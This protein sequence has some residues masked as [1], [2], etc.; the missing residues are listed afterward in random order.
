MITL[1]SFLL[2]LS[3]VVRSV[4]NC[5]TLVMPPPLPQRVFSSQIYFSM[6]VIAQSE[7]NF[8]NYSQARTFFSDLVLK[9]LLNFTL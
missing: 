2:P 3:Y 9:L 5:I 6:T 4:L 8:E 1:F 7:P